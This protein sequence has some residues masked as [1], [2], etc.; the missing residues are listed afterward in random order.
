MTGIVTR[1]FFDF[2]LSSIKLAVA[3]QTKQ[4]ENYEIIGESQIS[5]NTG[6]QVKRKYRQIVV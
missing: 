1:A 5:G 4:D 3:H 2:W 6:S